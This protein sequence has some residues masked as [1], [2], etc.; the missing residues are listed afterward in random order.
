M[1]NIAR[2]TLNYAGIVTLSRQ[3]GNK[4]IK[5]AE[6][7]NTGGASLFSFLA[8]CLSWDFSSAYAN[9]PA[10]IKLLSYNKDPDGD[11]KDSY[12][13]V[14][15]FIFARTS[16][17]VISGTG[18]CRVRYSF[19][20]PRDLVESIPQSSSDFG[21]GLYAHNAE[22]DDTKN[23]IAF[24]SLTTDN[25]TLMSNTLVNSSLLVDWELLVTNNSTKSKE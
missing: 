22:E 13:P 16:P 3:I 6:V 21:I 23:F 20:V 2:N 4:N 14:S 11:G 17:E 9:R 12:T 25:D 19:T 10:K 15:G 5:V 8:S 1:K 24:C 18:E 7:H